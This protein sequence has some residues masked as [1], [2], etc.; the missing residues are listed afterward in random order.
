[1]TQ[2]ADALLHGQAPSS[3]AWKSIAP[4][5]INAAAKRLFELDTERWTAGAAAE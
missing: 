1:M 4:A 3:V 5:D 2:L